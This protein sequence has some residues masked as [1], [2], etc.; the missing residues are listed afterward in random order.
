MRHRPAG[1][2][3]KSRTAASFGPCVT[4]TGIALSVREWI[5]RAK[6][7]RFALVGGKTPD[8]LLDESI[9]ESDD[10]LDLAA[11]GAEFGTEPA[12]VDVD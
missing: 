7:W 2:F 4:T 6:Y 3:E 8:P 10:G 1:T 11:G 5:S 12:D 9:A